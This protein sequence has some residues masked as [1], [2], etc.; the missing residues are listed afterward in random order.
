MSSRRAL[1]TFGLG[2][3]VPAKRRSESRTNRVQ[4]DPER[5]T[6]SDERLP[7]VVG[8]ATGLHIG[9]MCWNGTLLDPHN[10]QMPSSDASFY[11]VFH[12]ATAAGGA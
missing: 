2:S 1:S 6:P 7:G 3:G 4:K 9:G 12:W 8:I 5:P 10:L 11:L